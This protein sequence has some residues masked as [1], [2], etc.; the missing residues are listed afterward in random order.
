LLLAASVTLALAKKVE[1]LRV[2]LLI[3]PPLLEDP[4]K[5]I[6]LKNT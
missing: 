2:F 5:Q 3:A 4:K 6:D 1:N